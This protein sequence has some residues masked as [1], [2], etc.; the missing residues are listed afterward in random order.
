MRRPGA[1][2]CALIPIRK[3]A[4]WWSLTQDERRSILEERSHHVKTGLKYLPAVAPRL[5]H[6]LYHGAA[7]SFDLVTLF[8]SAKGDAAAIEA[9]G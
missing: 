6:S 1:S 5:Q 7:E 3:D 8:D 4:K 9:R 2:H